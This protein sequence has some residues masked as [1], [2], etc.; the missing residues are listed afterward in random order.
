[1]KKILTIIWQDDFSRRSLKT[2]LALGASSL[3]L[4]IIF[5]AQ[6]PPQ[7]PLFYS[8]PWGEEQLAS[9]LLL[10]L[11]PGSV[12]AIIFF[13]LIST[14]FFPEEKLLLRTL[15]LT[16]LLCVFLG[17]FALIKIILLTV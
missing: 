4:L 17:L 3:F 7:V 12:L 13:N 9:P 5:W 8:L 2:G 6:L 1:M 16:S 10:L 15:S 11:V 14:A